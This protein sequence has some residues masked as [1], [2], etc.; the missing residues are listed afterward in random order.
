LL[1][2]D[3]AR[4]AQ[5]EH[6][7]DRARGDCRERKQDA[8]DSGRIEQRAGTLYA[9]GVVGLQERGV[10]RSR[11]EGESED[12]RDGGKVE[13]YDGPP[14]APECPSVGEEQ[15]NEGEHREDDGPASKDESQFATAPP[16]R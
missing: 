1:A 11:F 8:G 12:Q 13:P 3:A 15:E 16:G 4:P 5:A 10:E 9:E 14:A 2:L 7:G 6:Q